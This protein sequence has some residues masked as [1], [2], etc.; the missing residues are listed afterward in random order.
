MKSFVIITILSSIAILA[1]AV[2]LSFQNTA[3]SYSE[4]DSNRPNAEILENK[5]DFG[6][7]TV[8]DVKEKDFLIKNI[9]KS[10][11]II[12]KV[13]TS[14]DC[15]YAYIIDAQGEKSPRFSMGSPSKWQINISP[16]ESV[17]LKTIY[18][19]AI[20]PVSGL[21]NRTITVSTNDPLQPKL[22]FQLTAEV[23][24]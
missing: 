5:Y 18:E 6:K 12:N 9:G 2:M 3:P 10:D 8:K 20:M 13:V 1:F 4:N 21:V 19:P 15:A 23:S 11:L 14:C 17:T 7:I 24:K 16:N 22:D